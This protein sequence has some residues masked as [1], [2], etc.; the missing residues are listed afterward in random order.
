MSELDQ[1]FIGQC[2]FTIPFTH[3]EFLKECCGMEKNSNRHNRWEPIFSHSYGEVYIE[4]DNSCYYSDS[5]D[6]LIAYMSWILS[7]NEKV[8]IDV[9][10]SHFYWGIHDVQH[11]INDESGCTIYVD[12]HIEKER[13][14]DGFKIMNELG[15]YPTYE[16]VEEIAEA[17]K[18]RFNMDIDLYEFLEEEALYY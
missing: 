6:I 13:L 3:K 14:I 8:E 11:A 1:E 5:P 2:R 17:F 18:Q 9:Q 16:M 10:Y 12:G 4:D 15:H 7:D